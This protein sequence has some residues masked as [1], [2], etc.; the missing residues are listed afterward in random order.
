MME[1]I[2]TSPL[3]PL[4]PES[5]AWTTIAT[6]GGT[7]GKAAPLPRIAANPAGKGEPVAPPAAEPSLL[8]T[9]GGW[10]KVWQ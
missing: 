8:D 5:I 9:I 7:E 10:F 2:A 1:E 4:A 3:Q 6:E